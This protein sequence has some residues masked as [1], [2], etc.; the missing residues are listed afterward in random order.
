MKRA[1][2]RHDHRFHQLLGCLIVTAIVSGAT[3]SWKETDSEQLKPRHE[4]VLNEFVQ[5]FHDLAMFDGTLLI[6]RGRTVL[7]EESWGMAHYESSTP[8]D[9]NTRFKIASVSKMIT[10]IAIARFVQAD[11]LQL[12]APIESY[13]PDF[14]SGK[15]ITLRQIVNHRSGIPHTNSQPWGDGKTSLTLDALVL[16]LGRLPLDFE[17]G[18]DQRYSN[19]GYA[20]AAKLLE[21]VAESSY[22]E[23]LETAV[24]S[25][26]GMK[27][28]GHIDDVRRPIS[29]LASGYEPSDFPGERRHSR[30]YAAESRTGG[31][32][33]YSTVDDLYR[34]TQAVFQEDFVPETLRREILGVTPEDSSFASQGRAPGFVANLYYDFEKD[35]VVISLA[36]NYSVPTD[37]G[38]ALVD[39]ATQGEL[40][41]SWPDLHPSP[42]FEAQNHP[43]PGTYSSTRGT[44]TVR[45]TARGAIVLEN[46]S[47]DSRTAFVPLSDGSFLL[48]LY[49]QRCQWESDTKSFTCGML[50]GDARYT[51]TRTRTGD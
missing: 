51:S 25:P 13:L 9:S 7:F 8:I 41:S 45:K 1:I 50:S 26:L 23:V 36:N 10:D 31:G 46:S 30:F 2:I 40:D 4:E 18:T 48:P 24:F 19:G 16:R 22:A 29:N 42:R 33:L 35:I 6:A 37:W 11:K 5:Q 38:R 14:P 20:V 39:L 15:K 34:L 21:V 28:S 43:Q 49:F 32:S 47:S 27:N 12:D 44:D 17:P 3:P